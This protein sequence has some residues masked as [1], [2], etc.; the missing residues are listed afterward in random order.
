[1]S[2]VLH[3][4]RRCSQVFA[5]GQSLLWSIRSLQ[6]IGP[7]LRLCVTSAYYDSLFYDKGSLATFQP[8]TGGPLLIKRPSLLFPYAGSY[9]HVWGNSLPSWQ[10][11]SEAIN[12]TF[13]KLSGWILMKEKWMQICVLYVNQ[14]LHIRLKF[15]PNLYFV[16]Y[17]KYD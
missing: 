1:M 10:E 5:T 15:H 4:I 9:S 6:R 13:L 17:I 14:N 8:Q 3:K 7:N 2:V 16:L 11:A 12:L